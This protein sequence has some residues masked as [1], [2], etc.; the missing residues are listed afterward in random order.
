M[1][2]IEVTG[3]DRGKSK[4]TKLR[5]GGAAFSRPKEFDHPAIRKKIAEMFSAQGGARPRG[6]KARKR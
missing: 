4:M 6:K 3:E 2:I 1:A 5:G